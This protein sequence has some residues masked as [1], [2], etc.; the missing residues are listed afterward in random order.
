MPGWR[1]TTSGATPACGAPWLSSIVQRRSATCHSRNSV[2][3]GLVASPRRDTIR[4][5]SSETSDRVGG[6]AHAHAHGAV[7]LGD[8]RVDPVH[9]ADHLL[10]QTFLGRTKVVETPAVHHGDAVRECGGL[11]EI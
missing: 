6:S 8:P 7:L 10:A 4:S 9:V 5:S 11:L 3:S 1:T 2:G